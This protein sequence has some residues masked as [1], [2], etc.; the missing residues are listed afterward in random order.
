MANDVK[1]KCKFGNNRDEGKIKYA[2]G[3][4]E[5]YFGRARKPILF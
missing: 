5:I 4:R 3:K 2:V 1:T